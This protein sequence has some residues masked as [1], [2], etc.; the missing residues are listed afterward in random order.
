LRGGDT[1]EREWKTY[2]FPRGTERGQFQLWIDGN[3]AKNVTD[4]MIKAKDD[5]MALYGRDDVDEFEEE[6]Y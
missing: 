4:E 2:E 5:P 3:Y 1:R 6:E